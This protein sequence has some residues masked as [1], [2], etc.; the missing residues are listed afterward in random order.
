MAWFVIA[1]SS[2][3]F[4][5]AGDK[6]LEI[7]GAKWIWN[8]NSQTTS[9][10]GHDTAS[11]SVRY[12][13]PAAKGTSGQALI[14]DSIA[15]DL[16]RL[17]FGTPSS[18][19][20]HNILSAT[21]SDATTGGVLRGDLI[22]GFA[23]G[24]WRRLGKG[25]NEEVLVSDGTDTSWGTV[26]ISGG[27]NLAVTA[28]ITLTGDS[29]GIVNQGTTT[30]V[31]HGNAGGNASFGI[32][33]IS[34]DTNLAVDTDHLKL[35]D[36]TLS[37]SDNEKLVAHS[38]Q[39]SFLQQIDFTVSEAGGTV[40]GSLEKEGGG[41]LTQFW[42][43]DYDVL[44]CT[45]P[46][47]TVNLTAFVGT[48]TSPA[49]VFVYILQSAKTTLVA[50]TSFPANSVEH[51]R[52]CSLVLQSAVTTG[53]DG[54][55]MVRNWNDPA[56]GITNPRGGD[57]V[58]S[59]RVRKEHA[60]HN[61][62]VVLSI[63]GDG[64]STITLDTTAGTVYQFN[65]QAFPAIDMAGADDIHL[66]NLVGS[67][68]ST[69]VNLVADITTL[70]DGVTS[71]NNNKYFNVVV[72]GVQNRTG[73]KSHLM[74]NLP[75]GQYNTSL[76]GTTDASKFSVH[77]IPSAFRGTGFLIAELTFQ[78]TG[79]GST[80]TLIQNKD[81]LG[82]TPTLVPGGG[83]TT[84][85]SIFS[86]SAFE[87]F[88]NGDDS[89]EG[90]FE[91]SGITTGNKRTLTWPDASGNMALTSQTDGTIDHGADVSGLTDDDHSAYVLDA[92][93]P[94]DNTLIRADGTGGRI[95]QTSGVVIDDSDNISGL[96]S[97]T[98]GQLDVSAPDT[99]QHI[100]TVTSSDTVTVE[101]AEVLEHTSDAVTGV[102]FGVSIK[103]M[104]SDPCFTDVLLGSMNW[105]RQTAGNTAQF[106]IIVNQAG[107]SRFVFVADLDGDTTLKA[108]N[109]DLFLEAVDDVQIQ[110]TDD[111]FI[112]PGGE[113][114]AS[115]G[116][117]IGTK[118]VGKRI[119]DSSDGSVSTT[120]FIGD[121]S[122]DTTP[123][124]LSMK[125]NITDS[126]RD[127]WSL[128]NKL[129]IVDFDWKEPSKGT[130]RATGLIAQE[131]Y[132]I[133]ELRQYTRYPKT[134]IDPNSGLEIQEGGW[135]GRW[136][137]MVPMLIKGMLELKAEIEELKAWKEKHEKEIP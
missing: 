109:G 18:A 12:Q 49:A 25:A 51:I 52:I 44:D 107:V 97:I 17:I 87:V 47:C 63:T 46:V 30:T 39:G 28:P 1:L 78:L 104:Y 56:F 86:D 58:S 114:I 50:N 95:M 4:G 120:L 27:T 122:I 112:S 94:A 130:E 108:W 128:F 113:F 91:L 83:T 124:S 22:Y 133:P 43:D 9:I 45:G 111:A 16:V 121:E 129:R 48:D 82:Q 37:L 135:G 79:G 134:V 98:G 7:D 32:V 105:R 116:V 55:L 115:S 70:A 126:T 24:D 54:A 103:I 13:M 60:L 34:D 102:G 75:T 106:D 67:E 14:I 80:W 69:S 85:I 10:A 20:A 21:H 38:R 15:S 62:G 100:L 73:E 127:V 26:D 61:S 57:I 29:V 93:T 3:A 77:T 119:D 136:N 81:L 41:D 74:C 137:M 110:P 117:M 96:G 72:W 71:L 42:S 8:S 125:K 118:S 89:K 101:Q 53:T 66:V 84:A 31:L 23:D 76:A 5:V 36:D 59:E 19:A 35:T 40:T 123:S 88:D 132:E 90:A 64:T 68:Y 131:V 6:E 92:G 33:D 65:L 2:V 99:V 11:E